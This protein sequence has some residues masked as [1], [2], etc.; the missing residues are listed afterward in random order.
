MPYKSYETIAWKSYVNDTEIVT[1]L[2]SCY[3]WKVEGQMNDSCTNHLYGSFAN[4]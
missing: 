2:N 4:T 3:G 1:M